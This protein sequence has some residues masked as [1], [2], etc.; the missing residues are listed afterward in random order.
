MAK[1]DSLVEWVNGSADVPSKGSSYAL[2]IPDL[3]EVTNILF[4][5]GEK[6]L[7]PILMFL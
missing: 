7:P 2:Y 6:E 5:S 1:T 4:S 3:F